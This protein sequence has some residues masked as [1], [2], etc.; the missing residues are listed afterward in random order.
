[1][2]NV[3]WREPASI[4]EALDLLA[5]HREE[6]KLLAG[7][8][9]LALVLRQGLLAP[10][11]LVSL[12]RIHGLN[13]ISVSGDGSVH[14]GP[15][16]RLRQVE[17]SAIVRER[18][19]V[20]ADTLAEV[21]NVRVR[22]Q[23]TIGG[24]LCDADYASDPPALLA[25]LGAVVELRSRRGTR[26]VAVRD[27]IV[28]HYATVVEPDELLADVA[29]PPLP[30]GAG[31]AYLKFRTRS[32]EDRPCVGVATVAALDSD[33]RCRHLE[34][35][36]GAV[37]DRP[38]RF[39]DILAEFCGQPFDAASIDDLAAAYASRIDPISDLRGSAAYRRRMIYVFVRR[40]LRAAI[41]KAN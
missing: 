32:H 37:A 10:S 5:E 35:V 31:A 17:L 23:A 40:A 36:V 14:L 21:A 26:T 38:Q 33:R 13:N 39:P 24:N 3:D 22:L 11:L 19:P 28:G 18:L 29:I 7:G 27:L 8:T 2:T 16:A 15:M 34:V 9:W 1:L 25:A 20:L 6:A 41:A 30:A 4:D 12:H